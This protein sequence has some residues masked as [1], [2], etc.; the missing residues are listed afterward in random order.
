MCNTIVGSGAVGVGAASRYGSGSLRLWLRNTDFLANFHEISD[1][2]IL[3]LNITITDSRLLISLK[4]L[5]FGRTYFPV[6]RGTSSA[7][8]FSTGRSTPE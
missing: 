3:N 8:T 2:A 5:K 6:K 1:F 7:H 4:K